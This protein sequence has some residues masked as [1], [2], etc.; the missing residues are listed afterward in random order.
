MANATILYGCTP[1]G[2]VIL[3]RPGTLPEWLPPRRVLAEKAVTSV[4]AEPGPPI[5]VL[6]VAS[7][8][9]IVSENGGRT[10][11]D[12]QMPAPI[13]SLFS[14][15]EPPNLLAV[16]QGGQLLSSPDNGATWEELP[17]LSEHGDVRSFCVTDSRI[18]LVLEQ[19]GQTTL[20]A[21][22]PRVE[23][24]RTLVSGEMITAVACDLPAG[25][26]YAG[27][28]DGVRLS[29]NG[30]MSWTTLAGSPSSSEVIAV[31]PGVA[32]KSP[33]LVVGT[34]LGVR[35][36]QDGGV[37][38]QEADLGEAGGVSAIARDPERRDRLYVATSTGYLFESGNRGQSWERINP[39][40]L[41][42]AT[43]LY[44]LRI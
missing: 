32:G 25:N 31:I 18:Y 23:E 15:G 19:E 4:W 44:V 3:T 12:I 16:M 40:P 39:S 28:T 33:T 27:F 38:W 17:T 30:G 21:G 13:T 6:A 41:P 1:E 10:W 35:V 26:L 11:I 9:L 29:S 5:R 34:D 42:P 24:W 7:G 2:L 43:Y 22:N 20:L 8:G 37:L 36:S 14:F